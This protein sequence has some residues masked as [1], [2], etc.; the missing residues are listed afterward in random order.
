M[1]IAQSLASNKYL[2]HVSFLLPSCLDVD[3]F[4]SPN[5]P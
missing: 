2:T 5:R 1:H 4:V 3:E